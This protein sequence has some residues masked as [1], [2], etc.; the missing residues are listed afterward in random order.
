SRD[1]S[2][3]SKESCLKSGSIVHP[4]EKGHGTSRD[5]GDRNRHTR[6]RSTGNRSQNSLKTSS[7]REDKPFGRYDRCQDQSSNPRNRYSTH[8][9]SRGRY[10][11]KYHRGSRV[12]SHSTRS[13]CDEKTR[14]ETYHSMDRSSVSSRSQSAARSVSHVES[15]LGSDTKKH[16]K[17]KHTESSKFPFTDRSIVQ[18]DVLSGTRKVYCSTNDDQSDASAEGNDPCGDHQEHDEDEHYYSDISNGDLGAAESESRYTRQNK[19]KR[20]KIL[21]GLHDQDQH[22]QWDRIKKSDE[23]LQDGDQKLSVGLSQEADVEL[24]VECVTMRASSSSTGDGEIPVRKVNIKHHLKPVRI[25]DCKSQ[26]GANSGTKSAR[27]DHT[28]QLSSN[29]EQSVLSGQTSTTGEITDSTKLDASDHV[30]SMYEESCKSKCQ[31]KPVVQVKFDYSS[32]DEKVWVNSTTSEHGELAISAREPMMSGS[33]E[34]KHDAPETGNQELFP[35]KTRAEKSSDFNGKTQKH[36][37]KDSPTDKKDWK[38]KDRVNPRKINKPHNDLAAEG[39]SHFE[40]THHRRTPTT[41]HEQYNNRNYNLKSTDPSRRSNRVGRGVPGKYRYLRPSVSHSLS[42]PYQSIREKRRQFHHARD[43][44]GRSLHSSDADSEWHPRKQMRTDMN[45][46]I[47]AN[48]PWNCLPADNDSRAITTTG[49]GSQHSESFCYDEDF[50]PYMDQ[51]YRQGHPSDMEPSCSGVDVLPHQQASSHFPEDRKWNFYA[52]AEGD[53]WTLDDTRIVEAP[54]RE[55]NESNTDE[56]HFGRIQRNIKE[57]LQKLDDITWA[58]SLMD[59]DV[60]A[61][62]SRMPPERLARLTADSDMASEH[63]NT[64]LKML[65]H[66]VEPDRDVEEK[67]DNFSGNQFQESFQNDASV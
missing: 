47:K 8:K 63:R 20:I 64:F 41:S 35:T 46:R 26:H 65:C 67:V 49:R 16:Q 11:E 66:G 31:K 59:H 18:V 42:K 43:D 34:T 17:M 61:T 22:H 27:L 32:K 30:K 51:D 19:S 54:V 10:T 24:P 53:L 48:E 57:F 38:Y 1:R 44:G 21:K 25:P 50:R 36:D 23:I 29:V 40:G 55:F 37:K 6:S 7:N 2:S 33:L 60:I 28:G 39:K 14:S 3:R 13:R 4:P 58:L 5:Y 12:S 62:L 15:A 9:G 56:V 52:N 45:L